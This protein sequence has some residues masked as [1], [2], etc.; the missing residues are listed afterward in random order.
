MSFYLESADEPFRQDVE[1]LKHVN[2]NAHLYF[3]LIAF[4]TLRFGS[5][6]LN[7]H[8]AGREFEPEAARHTRGSA[9]LC[10]VTSDPLLEWQQHLKECSVEI[11]AG[12]IAQVGAIGPMQSIYLY[13]PDGNLLELAQYL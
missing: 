11:I 12:P 1:P 2:D 7:L 4:Q 13:D 3:D 10:F 9:D 8:E 5:Q 6:K